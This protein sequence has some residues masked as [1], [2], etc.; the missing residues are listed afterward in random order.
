MSL[1]ILVD[2]SYLITL[3]VSD[4]RLAKNETHLRIRQRKAALVNANFDF[5]PLKSSTATFYLM[6]D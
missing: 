3:S 4:C 2:P 1:V 6:L 5:A